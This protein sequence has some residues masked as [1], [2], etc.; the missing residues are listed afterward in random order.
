MKILVAEDDKVSRDFL[1]RFLSPYGVCDPVIDGLEALDALF[2]AMKEN[3]PYDLVCLDIMMPKVDGVRV[4]KAIRDMEKQKGM[5]PEK[6]SK[7]IITTALAGSD[8]IDKAWDIGC[9]SCIEK[10]IDTE[11]LISEIKRLGLISE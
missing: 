10:P 6:R 2:I 4:L 3:K 7:V 1:S 9:D 11:L 8:F 5:L